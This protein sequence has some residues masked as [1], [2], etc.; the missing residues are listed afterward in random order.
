MSGIEIVG[1]ISSIITLIDTA[2]QFYKAIKN[3]ERLP[4]AFQEVARR[5]PLIRSTLGVAQERIK[6]DDDRTTCEALKPTVESIK[7]RAECLTNIL[8]DV[9]LQ[10]KGSKFQHYR[11]VMRRFGKGSQVEELMKCM[12][13]DVHLLTGNQAIRAATESQITQL[14]TPV[15][16]TSEP[17]EPSGVIPLSKDTKTSAYAHH[18]TG[19]QFNNAGDG[20]QNNNTGEGRQ[21]FAHSMDFRAD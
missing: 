7:E 21:Y 5:L 20:T 1:L 11:V 16:E 10:P 6:Q 17:S 8:Q 18:G 2:A 4:P 13:E 15:S 12:L 19:Y 3:V 9:A 14:L